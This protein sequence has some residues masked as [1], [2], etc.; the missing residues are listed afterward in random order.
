[1][2]LNNSER[3]KTSINLICSV[4]S[5][6]TGLLVSFYL[7]PYII[8]TIGIEA[9]G[10]ISLANN[11]TTYA[12]LVVTALNAMA[13]RFILL[14][15]VNKDYKQANLYYN[16]VFWGNLI[17]V[18]ICLAI[19]LVLI[20]NLD[21]LIEVPQNLSGDVKILFSLVFLGFFLRTGAPNWDCGTY[22]T[23]RLDRTYIPSMLSSAFRCVFLLVVFSLFEP[24]VWMV[25]LCSLIIA[26]FL[27][28]VERHN[29][30]TLTPEL[31]IAFKQPVCS[32]SVIKELVGS[33]M[34]NSISSAGNMLLNSFD[35]LI[36]NVGLGA[37][38]MG[39]LSLSK[40]IPTI[41]IQLAESIRGA[42]GPEL[43]VFYA[44]GDRQGMLQTMRRAM[45]LTT[46]ILTIPI[47]GIIV[48][49]DRFYALW[50]PT[51]NAS[52]LSTLTILALV[53]YVL[54]S[55]IVILYSI[56]TIYNKVKYN[57]IAQ[58]VCGTVSMVTTLVLIQFTD[59][60]LYAV[61]GVSCAVGIIR[62]MFFT[63]PI[64]SKYIGVKWNTFYREVGIS[65]LCCI[66]VIGIGSIVRSFMPCDTWLTF[67]LTCGVIAA[68]GLCTNMLIVLNKEERRYLVALVKKRLPHRQ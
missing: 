26:V 25:S 53:N 51:Q 61:A 41:F 28:L 22:I 32:W 1:M 66:I 36:C 60:D 48:M 64:T 44:K 34:W 19:S 47:A 7:S 38:A 63:I 49:C 55:G 67:F 2:R 52:M 13:S 58:L 37:T 24:R 54:V 21:R 57:A 3:L 45:K 27:L 11:F 40:T 29:T 4:G 31:K 62:D 12:S 35:L 8:R 68:L 20:P 17:I 59:L 46:V 10:F 33:G 15:Y 14:A 5:M 6:I 30:H 23:N 9:N 43:N 56:F 18:A 50:A 42:F 39:V 65:I 16:S